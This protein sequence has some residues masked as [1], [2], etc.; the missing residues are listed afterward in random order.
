MTDIPIYCMIYNAMTIYILLPQQHSRERE[1]ERE[2]E[3]ERE[4]GREE[5]Y[6]EFVCVRV[7][8]GGGGMRY[9][10]HYTYIFDKLLSVLQRP[11][12]QSGENVSHSL[13]QL[14]H[15]IC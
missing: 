14:C 15:E 12:P 9:D 4:R 13:P 6:A 8:E 1:K 11:A 5:V 10:Y 2:R 7:E 3:R